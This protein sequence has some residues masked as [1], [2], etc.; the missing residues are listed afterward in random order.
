MDPKKYGFFDFNAKR[1]PITYT[2]PLARGNL[3]RTILCN[4]SKSACQSGKS[5]CQNFQLYY[6]DLCGC[7]DNCVNICPTN[8]E[9]EVETQ[10]NSN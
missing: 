8:D 3:L 4:Y 2:E 9:V 5:S 6:N 1:E 10:E 7:S